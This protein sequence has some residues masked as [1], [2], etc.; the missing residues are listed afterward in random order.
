MLSRWERCV[1]NL[2][3]STVNTRR[4]NTAYGTYQ[5]H[6]LFVSA[7]TGEVIQNQLRGIAQLASEGRTAKRRNRIDAKWDDGVESYIEAYNKLDLLTGQL[8]RHIHEHSA[9][10]AAKTAASTA[11]HHTK[12]HR[13]GIAWAIVLGILAAL[14]VLV[15]SLT[16][17]IQKFFGITP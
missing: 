14:L 9:V 11:A 3:R 15:P 4:S 16:A 13:W 10:I 5:K 12:L 2:T 8:S 17:A 7:P 1:K 6:G